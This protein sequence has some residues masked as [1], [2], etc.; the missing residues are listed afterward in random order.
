[1]PE[2]TRLS[3]IEKKLDEH[4]E[5]LANIQ[6]ALATIA[7]Q[8]ER[9]NQVRRDAADNKHKIEGLEK[10]IELLE[11]PEGYLA[12]IKQFQASCPRRQMKWVWGV[13]LSINVPLAILMIGIGVKLMASV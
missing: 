9:I 10:K 8:D 11:G 1:M 12:G 2:E 4:G 13:I 6:K 5:I 3:S 7:V